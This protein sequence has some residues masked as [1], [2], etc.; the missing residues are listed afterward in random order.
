MHGMPLQ[1]IDKVVYAV[2]DLCRDHELSGFIEGV[3]IGIRLADEV[4]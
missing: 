1:E 3:K 2:C 4:D